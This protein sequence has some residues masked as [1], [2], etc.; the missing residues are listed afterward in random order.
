M[1][2]AYRLAEGLPGAGHVVEVP[3]A[4]AANLTHPGPVNDALLWFLADL[5][6]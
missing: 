5:R 3:G 1:E 4:H 6:S 2:D